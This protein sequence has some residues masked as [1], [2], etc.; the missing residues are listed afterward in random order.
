VFLLGV[1]SY[2]RLVQTSIED[3]VYT[4][5]SFRIRDSLRRLDPVAAPIFPPTDPEGIRKLERM[6]SCRP[7]RSRRC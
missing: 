6:G 5:G 3:L 7:A 4:V 1:F 2:L